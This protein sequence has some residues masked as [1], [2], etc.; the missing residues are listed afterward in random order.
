M[1]KRRVDWALAQRQVAR[2]VKSINAVKEMV[3]DP[4]IR[5]MLGG[6]TETEQGILMEIA[7]KAASVGDPDPEQIREFMHE[8]VTGYKDKAV[9]KLMERVKV[10]D[11]DFQG[12]FW[13]LVREFSLIDA[14]ENYSII[15]ARLETID[16]LDIAIKAGAREVPDIHNIIK[17]FPWLLDPRWSLMGD[18]VPLRSLGL[19]YAP[20]IDEETGDRLDYLFALQ[21][22]PPA[23]LD[24][25]LVVEIKRGYKSN[26][27]VHRVNDA[28]ITKFQLY[29]L[30]IQRHYARNSTTPAVRGVMIANDYT[31]RADLLKQGI[32]HGTG[33]RLEFMTW[34]SVIDYTRRL[35]TGW[36]KVTRSASEQSQ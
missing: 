10:E 9:R 31:E 5:D 25:V 3:E 36:L 26:G 2:K 4:K 35:H 28:E 32:E 12:K 30:Q 6:F 22:E 18:E 15:K 24:Q 11:E 1:G 17:E 33:V 16:R 23:P 8:I 29:V 7:A 21:P 19:E 14:R 13:G 34:S 27:S 20:N